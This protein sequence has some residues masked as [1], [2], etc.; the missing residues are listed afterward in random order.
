MEYCGGRAFLQDLSLGR[1]IGPPEEDYRDG[2]KAY[3]YRLT[4]LFAYLV[5]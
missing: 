4:E 1:V 3:T 5:R 2:S